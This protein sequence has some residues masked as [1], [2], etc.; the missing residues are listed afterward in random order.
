M[1]GIL[2][3]LLGLFYANSLSAKPPCFYPFDYFLTAYY[4]LICLPE[5]YCPFIWATAMSELLKLS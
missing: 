4:A 5:K 3:T 1:E 2:L